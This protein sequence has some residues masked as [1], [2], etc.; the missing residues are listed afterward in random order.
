MLIKFCVYASISAEFSMGILENV[1]IKFLNMF[2]LP[3][4]NYKYFHSFLN[5]MVQNIL[6]FLHGAKELM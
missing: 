1:V 6:Q 5:W 4:Y 2:L 3:N